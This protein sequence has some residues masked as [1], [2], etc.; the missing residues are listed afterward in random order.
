MTRSKKLYEMLCFSAGVIAAGLFVC[1]AASNA[2]ALDMEQQ[3]TAQGLAKIVVS[4]PE[5]GF[6]IN[7]AALEAYY[8]QSGLDTPS[9]L[10]YINNM[11]T[12]LSGN[13]GDKSPCVLSRTTAK[14]IGVLQN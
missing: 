6:E 2:W 12:I 11:M 8:V 7:E 10:A 1:G 14:S 5:C 13:K 4:A 9:G 3:R